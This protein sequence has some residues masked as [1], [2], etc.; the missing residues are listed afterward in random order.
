VSERALPL[1]ESTKATTGLHSGTPHRRRPPY[2][3]GVSRRAHYAHFYGPRSVSPDDGPVVVVHGNCQAESLRVSLQGAQSPVTTVRIPPVH[4]LEA[5]DLEPL[6]SLVRCADVLVSQPIRPDYRGLP[7]GTAQLAALTRP[8]ARTVVV[9]IVRYAGLHPYQAIVRHP[10]EPAAV[11]PVVPYHDL[12]TVTA[13]RVGADP[14]TALR[15][16]GEVHSNPAVLREVARRSLAELARREARCDI[17]ISDLIQPLGRAAVHTINHPGNALLVAVTR[18][19]QE[20]LGLPVEAE[21]PGRVL[22]GGVRASVHPAVAAAHGLPVAGPTAWTVDETPVD[23]EYLVTTQLQWY[24]RH[25]W[26]VEAC[27]ARYGPL[28]E[29]LGL[30]GEDHELLSGPGHRDVPVDRSLDA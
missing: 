24:H 3:Q 5:D 20:A 13:A 30:A 29:L 9:P 22:L 12:R 1:A 4:E 15:R 21:D 7:V 18:R 10:S 14:G 19:L 26:F 8:A 6:R 25:P 11:P 27:V 28:L 2:S 17:A 16:H 23:D